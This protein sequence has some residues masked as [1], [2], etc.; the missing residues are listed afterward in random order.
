MRTKHVFK[1]T[2]FSFIS[3]IVLLI[4][5]MIMPRMIILTYGSGVN[6]LTSTITQILGILNLLQAGAVGASI[7]EMYRP[8]A[9]DDYSTISII[10]DSSKRY[11]IKLGLI[12]LALVI[13]IAPV[14]GIF[15]ANSELS[16]SEILMSVLI[17]GA[18]GSFNFFFFAWYDILF[19]S[20]QNRYILSI[21]SIIEMLA[22][23]GLLFIVLSCNV[24]F[25]W[26]YI[27]VLVGNLIEVFYLYVIYKKR[28]AAKFPH[29]PK[30]NPYKI[31]NRKYLLINQI[32]TQGVEASPVIILTVL[33]DFRIVS[34]FAIHN[35]ILNAI[36][37]AMNTIQ[38]SFSASLGNVIVTEEDET[39]KKIFD[40]LQLA[41]FVIG[42]W[43]CICTAFLFTPFIE[44]YTSG[45]TDA[46]YSRPMLVVGMVILCIVYCIFIPYAQVTNGYG[47]FKETYKQGLICAAIG[48]VLSLALASIDMS[49]VLYGSIFYYLSSFIYRA[50][51]MRKRSSWYKFGRLLL[52][53]AFTILLPFAAYCLSLIE[54]IHLTRWSQFFIYGVGTA[55]G[56]LV[57]ATAYCLIFERKASKELIGYAKVIVSKGE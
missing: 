47:L 23:Y 52:R 56:A 37:M 35:L 30:H 22:Y 24:H 46:E 32:S 25:I 55:A 7:F 19:S 51:I 17:L 48:I 42:M 50:Y 34:V 40:V 27:A 12:F 15:K 33:Y 53:I 36:K 45:I 3:E 21:G 2:V 5:G 1:N 43:L 44:L 39:V 8:V 11:F 41:C 13:A 57:L 29:P 10:M 31:K 38:Y 6:G 4:F 49:L 28:Y 16:F 20:Y 54:D 26:M 18:N 9:N 14:T